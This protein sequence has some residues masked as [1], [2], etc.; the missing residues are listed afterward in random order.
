[1]REKLF[2]S[3]IIIIIIEVLIT[4]LQFLVLERAHLTELYK[5]GMSLNACHVRKKN[6]AQFLSPEVLNSPARK[7]SRNKLTQ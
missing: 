6:L 5:A 4:F 7:V 1:M 3:G 2:N